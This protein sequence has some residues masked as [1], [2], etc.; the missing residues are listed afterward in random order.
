M[1]E[2]K[3]IQKLRITESLLM[4]LQR[5]GM[6]SHLVPTSFQHPPVL[7]RAAVGAGV[8]RL[9]CVGA[10]RLFGLLEGNA[11]GSPLALDHS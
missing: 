8:G 1:E 9:M 5:Y 7:S 6:L 4:S 3:K 10:S 11:K 2:E